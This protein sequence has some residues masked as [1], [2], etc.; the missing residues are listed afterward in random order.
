MNRRQTYGDAT[1]PMPSMDEVPEEY[2]ERLGDLFDTWRAV[3]A[4]NML[5]TAYYDMK[6]M[7]KDLGISIPEN[8]LSVN[9][10]VGW[11][12]KAVDARAVRSVFD[13]YV[14]EGKEDP[15]LSELVRL[16]RMRS[17]YTQAC[18]S[19]L[20]HGLSAVTVMK[21]RKGQPAAKVRVHSAN[22]F[23]ALWDKDEGRI[24]C[25]VVLSDVDRD[26]H[27][28]RYVAHFPDKVLTLERRAGERE[29][30]SC[31]QEDNPM[32]R[33]LMEVLVHDPDID[34]PL[35]HS[36]LTPE[37]LG[38][39]DKAMRDVLR[40][41]VGAEFFTFPQRYAL[42]VADDLFCAPPRGRPG[43]GR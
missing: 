16:N 21:G 28:A 1:L 42:G 35:G 26:G 25:G 32:G 31:E 7:L 8:L 29:S 19:L 13:G 3:R 10:A 24:G 9:C 43:G 37:L 11:C 36:L 27:A 23:A 12:A 33:P 5:L 30:W 40:M 38:I 41:E 20:V 15:G 14:F 2:R 34:R 17:L 39:V 6:N 22:Q 18:K 4:R